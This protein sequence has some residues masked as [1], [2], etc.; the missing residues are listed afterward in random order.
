MLPSIT[1]GAFTQECFGGSITDA[2]MVPDFDFAANHAMFDK[3]KI[4]AE[5]AEEEGT[6]DASYNLSGTTEL[7]V[8][9]NKVKKVGL[10]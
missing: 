5:F 7:L 2:D 3:K 1:A 9:Q 10:Q 6:N 4:F 8:D